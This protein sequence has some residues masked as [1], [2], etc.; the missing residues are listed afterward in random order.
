MLHS[1]ANDRNP[2]I[3]GD[4]LYEG[5]GVGPDMQIDAD[6]LAGNGTEHTERTSESA[7]AQT[8]EPS[9]SAGL[10]ISRCIS[11]VEIVKKEYF[12]ERKPKD[13]GL[14]QYNYLGSF[15][16]TSKTQKDPTGPNPLML[17]KHFNM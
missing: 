1:L 16:E 11:I 9:S 17:D 5:K 2:S 7:N 13:H 4:E 12:N 14:Y 10:Q 6:N 15:K 8:N 3:L